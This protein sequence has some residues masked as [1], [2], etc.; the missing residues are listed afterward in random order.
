[1]G[2]DWIGTDGGP[3][4]VL[5]TATAGAW[6]GS[7]TDCDTGD[8]ETWGD[9][10]LACTVNDYHGIVPFGP[11]SS[12]HRALVLG[13]EL[14]AAFLA[15]HQCIARWEHADSES[16]MLAMIDARLPAAQWES[17]LEWDAPP[18]GLVIIGAA[19]LFAEYE[20]GGIAG[21]APVRIDLP[22]GRYQVEFA[23]VAE[24]SAAAVLHRF[25]AGGPARRSVRAMR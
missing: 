23:R 16:D 14:D 1:M 4:V 22:A 24:G 17:R 6:G 9:Y 13:S 10:G 20:P 2:L 18:G 21:R 3:M 8:V 5:A 25:A 19:L 15:A 12:P 11:Q 7:E